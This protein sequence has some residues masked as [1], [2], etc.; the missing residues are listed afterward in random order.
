MMYSFTMLAAG[1]AM[2]VPAATPETTRYTTRADMQD[3]I[4]WHG[5]RTGCLFYVNLHKLA[6]VIVLSSFHALRI[7]DK[8][9]ATTLFM[10]RP[11]SFPFSHDYICSAA[12]MSAGTSCFL[13]E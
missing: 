11:F 3:C 6:S 4:P 8:T 12:R 10:R 5:Q 1:S 13:V 9:M 7:A 2:K